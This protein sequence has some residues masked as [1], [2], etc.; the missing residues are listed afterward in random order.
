M[1]TKGVSRPCLSPEEIVVLVEETAGGIPGE[2]EAHL[3]SCDTCRGRL[4]A[5]A[6]G[7]AEGPVSVP[8]PAALAAAAR[9]SWQAGRRAGRSPAR[10]L[11]PALGAAAA[12]VIALGIARLAGSSAPSRPFT[13]PAGERVAGREGTF[14]AGPTGTKSLSLPDGTRFRVGAGG[15][16]RFLASLPGE[17]CRIE[18][19]RGT[20]EAEVAKGDDRVRIVSPAGEITVL[21]TVFKARAFRI[22][23]SPVLAVEVAEGLVSVRG[24]GASHPVPAG[25][26]GIVRGG[27]KPF[28]CVQEAV[29][30]PW[31]EALARWGGAAASPGFSNRVECLTLLSG[32]WTGLSCWER[33]LDDPGARPAERTAAAALALLAA[34]GEDRARLVGRIADDAVARAVVLGC[35]SAMPARDDAPPEGGQ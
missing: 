34:E 3:G 4:S 13:L 31:R 33:V 10:Y 24:A 11:V 32:T 15:E 18:L 12:V 1:K 8:D 21:G 9:A 22:A 17:R 23:G 16:I 5:V 30:L 7:P 14:R 27:E 26:R 20:L 35:R 2:V 29:P 6:A 28:A 25:R 19:A